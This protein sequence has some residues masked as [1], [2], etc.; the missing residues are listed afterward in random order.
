MFQLGAGMYFKVFVATGSTTR[1][2]E[3]QRWERRIG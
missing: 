2:Q 1:L 3:S